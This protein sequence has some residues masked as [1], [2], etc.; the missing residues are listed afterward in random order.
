MVGAEQE[1]DC[2]DWLGQCAGSSWGTWMAQLETQPQA[3]RAVVKDSQLVQVPSTVLTGMP[4][5]ETSPVETITYNI[6]P[7]A[8]WSDGVP[9]SCADFQYTDGAAAERPRHLR[10]YGLHRHRHR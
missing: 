1:P 2:F 5:F 9:I 6:T 10:P 8:V 3:F 7:A 4:K